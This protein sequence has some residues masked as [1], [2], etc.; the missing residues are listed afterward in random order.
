MIRKF[1]FQG[2]A[3]EPYE[4]VFRLDGS[5]L[6]AYCTCP[7]GTNG[8]YCKHRF[9]ILKG[10]SKGVVSDNAS[11]FAEVAAWLPGTDIEAAMVQVEALEAQANQIQNALSKAKKDLAKSMRN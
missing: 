11:Q 8:M 1:L 9:A 6:S 3:S 5:N 4:V 10:L 2:S 7:A